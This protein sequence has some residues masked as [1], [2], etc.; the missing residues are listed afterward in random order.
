M[1]ARPEVPGLATLRQQDPLA[2]ARVSAYVD[3]LIHLTEAA[4]WAYPRA[5]ELAGE[6]AAAVLRGLIGEARRVV[7]D[8][9]V[10]ALQWSGTLAD[11]RV[12][13]LLGDADSLA[14]DEVPS[15]DG[16]S[17]TLLGK[18]IAT[19]RAAWR[20]EGA[21]GATRSL[22][23]FESAGCVPVGPDAALYLTH[24]RPH[25]FLGPQRARMEAL[26][27]IAA[28]FLQGAGRPEVESD[29]TAP[30]IPGLVGT[31][32]PMRELHA[33]VL[34]FAAVPW[35]VLILGETGTGKEAVARALHTLS[36]RSAQPFLVF[37]CG[38]VPPDLTESFLFGHEKGAFTGAD[39]RKEGMCERV[40]SGTLFLDEVGEL[41]PRAQVSLLR[42][43][44]ER[45]FERLGG[46]GELVFGGRVV[47]ATWRSLDDAA[48]KGEFRSDLFHRIGACVVRV[49]ALR[50]RR[51]DIPALATHLLAR[52]AH[53]MGYTPRVHLDE[54]AMT[55]LSTR[56]WPGNVRELQN[57][58]REALARTVAAGEGVIRLPSVSG[59]EAAAPEVPEPDPS[60]PLDLLAA[61]DAYQRR[62]VRAALEQ[63]RWNRTDAAAHL[64]VSRQWLHRLLQRWGGEP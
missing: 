13:R 50:E 29:P 34:A 4:A 23:G 44:Q 37:N 28:A 61:T 30:S 58:L 63:C 35:P 42:L 38:A 16:V 32:R 54:A 2:A 46:A 24:A 39:R 45:R 48:R 51:E 36:P 55:S 64:G 12:T 14:D 6:D 47:A 26:A 33:S 53:E 56:A 5:P 41:S 60:G 3:E 10:V 19:G 11:F 27:A 15:L 25:Q 57:T 7:P 43:V 31:S 1:K 49:P 52:A 62:L 59:S 22:V 18:T 20:D 21:A 8:A 40:G 9:Q 17:R